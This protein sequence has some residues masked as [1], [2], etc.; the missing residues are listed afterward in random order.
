[1]T[2]ALGTHP[3][4]RPGLPRRIFVAGWVLRQAVLPLIAA[5]LFDLSTG[6]SAWGWLLTS[7]ICCTIL[8]TFIQRRAWA[9]SS[10]PGEVT[11][12]GRN[13]PP[14]LL[15]AS[16]ILALLVTTALVFALAL[17]S[18]LLGML[19]GI[20]FAAA[21]L[22]H[23]AADAAIRFLRVGGM[24]QQFMIARIVV[25][26]VLVVVSVTPAFLAARTGAG[27]ASAALAVGTVIVVAGALTLLTRP[28]RG[29]R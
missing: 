7:S 10:L 5:V 17:S 24:L 6:G 13:A 15:L 21:L 29:V 19:A 26:A 9:L 18:S 11:Q 3:A 14:A 4:N 2:L 25:A 8:A 1:M 16:E 27:V 23:F 20:L 28:G 12:A 22:G